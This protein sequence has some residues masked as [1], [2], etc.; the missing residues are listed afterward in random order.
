MVN[1]SDYAEVSYVFLSVHM[2]LDKLEFV[3]RIDDHEGYASDP[4]IHTSHTHT[5]THHAHYTHHT[6]KDTHTPHTSTDNT[7]M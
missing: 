4:V 2:V 6:P 3:E 5:H 7:P 1:V